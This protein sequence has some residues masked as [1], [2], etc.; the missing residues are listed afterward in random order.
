M[1]DLR[2]KIISEAGKLFYTYGFKRVSMDEI[3]SKSK[4][5]K[6][7]LYTAFGS[8]NEIMKIFLERKVDQFADD[9]DALFD[10]S[11]PVEDTFREYIGLFKRLSFSISTPMVSDMKYMPEMFD[12]VDKKRR[13]MLLKYKVIL[14]KAKEEGIISPDLNT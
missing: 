7:T 8:K 3:A 4:I 6:K 11:L 1:N 9:V 12:I 2:E 13:K 5:S 14:D 10:T